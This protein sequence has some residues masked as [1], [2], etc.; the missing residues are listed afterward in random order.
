MD[1]VAKN[2]EKL[3]MERSEEGVGDETE[4]FTQEQ[5]N[6]VRK[7]KIDILDEVKEIINNE[8]SAFA[9]SFTQHQ[10]SFAADLAAESSH[11]SPDYQQNPGKKHKTY[12]LTLPK[13][14]NWHFAER[15]GH[16]SEAEGPGKR[17][18]GCVKDEPLR[19]ISV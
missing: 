1:L 14:I 5:M 9:R 19:N 7:Y 4:I 12:L 16:I 8:K 10:E 17:H 15:I 18:S 3:E 2:R 11:Y 6:T 13:T